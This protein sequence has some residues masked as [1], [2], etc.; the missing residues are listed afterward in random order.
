MPS[1]PRRADAAELE[2][3]RLE[4]TEAMNALTAEVDALVRR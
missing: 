1:P 4:V 2:R 3:K